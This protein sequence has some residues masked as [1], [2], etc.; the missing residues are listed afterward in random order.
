MMMLPMHWRSEVAKIWETFS[1]PNW[2]AARMMIFTA[3]QTE[4]REDVQ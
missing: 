3:S 2:L 4:Q 1:I